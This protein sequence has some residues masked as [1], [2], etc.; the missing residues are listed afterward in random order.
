MDTFQALKLKA[1]LKIYKYNMT[2]GYFEKNYYLR[3]RNS[4]L[5]RQLPASGKT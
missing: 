5:T 3:Q 4:N 2:W 1:E